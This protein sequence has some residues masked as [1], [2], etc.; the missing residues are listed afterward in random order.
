MLSKGPVLIGSGKGGVNIEDVA[1]EDPNAIFTIPIDITKGMTKHD[2]EQMVKKMGFHDT[3]HDQA[4]EVLMK[5]YNLFIQSDCN[6]IEINP[7]A[8]DVN[9][10]G[11]R[12][13]KSLLIIAYV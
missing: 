4:I 6:L 8:E 7:M 1:K 11:L 10:K 2:A 13:F 9:G 5:L 12:F 3:C